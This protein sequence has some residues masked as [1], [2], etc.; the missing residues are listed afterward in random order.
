MSTETGTPTSNITTGSAR[1]APVLKRRILVLDDEVA[2]QNLLRVV[3]ESEGYQV[4]NTDDGRAALKMI[5]EHKIEL[6]IQDLR[7]PKLDGLSFLKQLKQQY[8]DVPSIVITAFGTF[9]TTIEA[10][11]LG[12]YTHLNKPFDTEEIRSTVSRAL[13]RLEIGKRSPRSGSVP[14][15]DIISHTSL[16]A[17]I[18]NLVDR[19]APTD[20]TVLITGES[21]TGKELI[22]RAIHYNS[23]RADQAFVPIN[24]GA[25]TET[26]LESELFGHVKGS[27]TGAIGD[28]KG[29]F[30]SADRGTLFL[31]EV[32][33]LSLATQVK[34]L[35]VLETRMVKPVGGSRESKVDVRF[36]C[37]TNR[38]LS[39]MVAEGQFREDLFYRLNV[40]PLE[41]PP[42]RDRKE[43]IPL[44][45]GYF[46]ARFAKRMNKPM[47][48]IDDAVIERLLQYEWP[49]NVRELENTIE[50][51][52]AL[53]RNDRITLADLNGPGFS[54]SAA[55][56]R[57]APVSA[58]IAKA[59]ALSN[60]PISA[61]GSISDAPRLPAEGMD[62]E[63]WLLDQERALILQALERTNGS[64][65]LAAKL[66]NMTFRSIRYRVSK[67]GIER[68]SKD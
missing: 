46:L 44:L 15:L 60:V 14:F 67:L 63:K 57:R 64:L 16:M 8:P 56:A 6:V 20:S 61:P 58:S 43:D 55:S 40:I 36:I 7:M 18:S 65:T 39:Q 53:T 23:L 48:G 32:G 1:T 37:A 33:E 25:F 54:S 50:R 47:T 59:D 10:M 49:G 45:A 11:R 68:P 4:F 3:L 38:N 27:F 28:R 17:E 2:I 29:V 51:A 5:G 22:A 66:L 24:C 62:L 31:D 41:L 19:V 42:L 9:E 13:E 34:F 26:L 52:V 35:R 30:E 21:G 12:A